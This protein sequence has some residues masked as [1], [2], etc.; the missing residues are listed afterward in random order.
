MPRT[1]PILAATAAVLLLGGG[2]E[3]WT[4]RWTSGRGQ[5]L[6]AAAA[7]LGRVA[8]AIGDWTGQELEL[9]ARENARTGIS[10]G[11]LRRYVSRRTG[12]P[13]TVLIVCGRPGPISVHTPEVCY[14]GAGYEVIEPR[15]RSIVPIAAGTPAAEL[16]KVRLRKVESIVPEVLA[17]HYAW[18]ATGV[19]R[20][21]GRDPRF[22]FAGHPVLYKLYVIEQLA[23]A[24]EAET[25]LS[26]EFIR[27]LMPAL[28]EA[29]FAAGST[30]KAGA[31]GSRKA[32][33]GE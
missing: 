28:G 6:E 33:R 20:A 15:T 25:D 16:W 12:A 4:D 18:S 3:I 31:E 10:A 13:V 26:R 17:A 24:D 30:I 7:R 1:L 14:A 27:V 5:D 19:W 11:L 32:A 29:L 23:P 8:L 21:P 9:D 22:E 2:G